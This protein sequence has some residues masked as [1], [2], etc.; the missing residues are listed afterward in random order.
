MSNDND[1][2]ESRLNA[3]QLLFKWMNGDAGA[4]STGRIL[5]REWYERTISDEELYKILASAF[6]KD[7]ALYLLGEFPDP[8][9]SKAKVEALFIQ[10]ND[11]S[12]GQIKAPAFVPGLDP[13]VPADC[14]TILAGDAGVGKSVGLMSLLAL[15]KLPIVWCGLEDDVHTVSRARW[16]AAGG[17]DEKIVWFKHS[18]S[19]DLHDPRFADEI[20]RESVP[21]A[22]LVFD[23]LMAWNPTGEMNEAKMIR[24]F[25]EALKPIFERASLA[26]AI[27]IHHHRKS[28]A[29][30]AAQRV[31]GSHQIVAA[32]RSVLVISKDPDDEERRI[33]SHAKSN[34]AKLGTSRVFV[35]EGIQLEGVEGS[36]PRIVWGAVDPRSADDLARASEVDATQ[37]AQDHADAEE[38]IHLLAEVIKAGALPETGV[39]QDR[40]STP[41]ILEIAKREPGRFEQP[42]GKM[43]RIG[44][45]LRMA[46]IRYDHNEKGRFPG[47]YAARF[48]YLEDVLSFGD[49]V[50]AL[51]DGK[52]V[53]AL[54]PESGN[55]GNA[56]T[57]SR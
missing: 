51:P 44:K 39:T 40:I 35:I 32:A 9:S 36:I 24:T 14:H 1:T 34:Y 18:M 11:P 45:L 54:D 42:V 53:A 7:T 10:G 38:L 43:G 57:L 49:S 21:G 27:T 12:L 46:G 13:Y 5:Q 31:A 16:R 50:A 23:S 26:A 30:S 25:D 2:S 47:M 6:H 29:H 48:I 22:I 37:T 3:S 55:S 41:V 8:E 56:A 28:T 15:T 4:V 19:V 17:D 52:N 20:V 33:L